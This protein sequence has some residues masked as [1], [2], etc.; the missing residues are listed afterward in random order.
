MTF[1]KTTQKDFVKTALRL[2]PELHA[3]VHAAAKEKE[4]TYNG[5]IL[6][7]L[8]ESFKSGAGKKTDT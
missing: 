4:R 2:P 5:E 7:R 1:K 6:H 8:R 3:A